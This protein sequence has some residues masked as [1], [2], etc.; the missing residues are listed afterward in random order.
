MTAMESPWADV[1]GM[2]WYGHENQGLKAVPQ[3]TAEPGREP[4]AAVAHLVR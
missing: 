2:S 3:Y 1:P 4:R